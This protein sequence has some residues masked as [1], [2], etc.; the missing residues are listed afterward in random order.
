MLHLHKSQILNERSLHQAHWLEVTEILYRDESGTE[1][2]WEAVHRRQRN[3]AAII[4]A[5]LRPS[6]KYILVRQ[7]RPPTQGYVLEFP[8]G[9]VDEGE[10][11]AEA[12]LREL[13]EETGFHGKVQGVTD[14]MY[15]SPGLLSEG[16]QYV[17]MT[18]DEQAPENQTPKQDTDPGEF[19]D[20]ITLHPAELT[21]LLQQ[22]TFRSTTLDVKLFAF[23]REHLL[24]LP[25]FDE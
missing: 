16:C 22:E 25:V 7:F 19:L 18:V 14:V 1:R 11:A 24:P 2:S 6:G 3:L 21:P 20:V 10:K 5:Q 23:F 9:L 8:A 15:S 4:V 13:R 17:F 12:G